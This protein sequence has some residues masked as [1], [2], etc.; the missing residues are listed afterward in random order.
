M[1]VIVGLGNPGRKYEA[2]RHNIGFRVV[3][4]LAERASD[5]RRQSLECAG[6]VRCT[7]AGTEVA[8]VWPATYM[9]RSGDAVR[10]A[11]GAFDARPED[12]LVVADDVYLPLGTLRFRVQGSDGGHNGLASVL[13]VAGHNR[14]PR[15]RVG[16][17]RG[18]APEDLVD[19]VLGEFTGEEAPA[20]EHIVAKA[21][22]CVELYLR[23]G[24]DAAMN[25]FNGI[26]LLA[27][28]RQADGEPGAADGATDAPSTSF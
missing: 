21:A 16:V 1:I 6:A 17:G 10:E 5:L 19:F 24:A 26:D 22:D 25:A 2:T 8:L 13:A 15:L 27:P 14:V 11:L 9:N 20:V 4:A 7:I 18:G 28:A 12:L 3:D 23:G